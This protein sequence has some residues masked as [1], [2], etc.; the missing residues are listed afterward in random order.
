MG[1]APGLLLMAA[2]LLFFYPL[3]LCTIVS[4]LMLFNFS[5]KRAWCFALGAGAALLFIV[6]A[7]LNAPLERKLEHLLSQEIQMA[8]PLEKLVSIAVLMPDDPR[9]KARQE[10]SSL[11]TN[12][13][14]RLLLQGPAQKVFF[15]RHSHLEKTGSLLDGFK[16]CSDTRRCAEKDQARLSDIEYILVLGETL[17]SKTLRND[18]KLDKKPYGSL[19]IPGQS[20]RQTSL[21]PDPLA[22]LEA[23]SN[24]LYRNSGGHLEIID[25][26]MIIKAAPLLSPLV[27]GPVERGSLKIDIRFVQKVFSHRRPQYYVG[28]PYLTPG[29]Y[30]RLF[31][32]PI[33]T[34]ED[35]DTAKVVE[36]LRKG[37]DN[38]LFGMPELEQLLQEDINVNERDKRGIPLLHHAVSSGKVPAV[39]LLLAHGADPN[40]LRA[41]G[42]SILSHIV[43]YKPNTELLLTL[44][45]A[46]AKP[47]A[48]ADKGPTA[49]FNLSDQ[50]PSDRQL[51][52]A[53]I[54][55]DYGADVSLKPDNKPS[56]LMWAARQGNLE[57]VKL[58][59]E[60]GPD[61]NDMTSYKHSPLMFAV[62]GARHVKGRPHAE[63]ISLLIERGA[64]VH[65]KNK[66]GETLRDIAKG[67]DPTVQAVIMKETEQ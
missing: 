5:R 11:C 35:L 41:D 53:K 14:A 67:A 65:V 30:N 18:K 12:T 33:I 54:L 2:P 42:T 25:K 1:V 31:G 58:F 40:M 46:G 15:G 44:L 29:F 49:L 52:L 63:I 19:H 7:V 23:Q 45:K 62:S 21:L 3:I 51:A 60:T 22:S 50:N 48:G 56:P 26:T 9:Q 13:C 66:Q 36:Q 43:V 24:T 37:S 32:A 6:P 8:I 16:K 10:A 59:L 64:D 61:V 57:L 34:Q 47:D 55:L 4:A 38:S 28:T 20:R 27:L 17:H 39:K